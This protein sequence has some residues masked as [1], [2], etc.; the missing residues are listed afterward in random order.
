MQ[1]LS[2]SKHR[3]ARTP[4]PSITDDYANKNFQFA[5]QV[6]PS[7]H[8][9]NNADSLHDSDLASTRQQQINSQYGTAQYGEYEQGSYGDM[10][11][12][13]RDAEVKHQRA[14]YD[15]AASG[16]YAAAQGGEQS[17]S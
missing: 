14:N 6:A 2:T 17:E 11:T 12:Q 7:S 3:R 15:L 9:T 16:E 13:A 1:T 5:S 8:G 10:T 4:L